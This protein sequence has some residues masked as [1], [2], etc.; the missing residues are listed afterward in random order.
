VYPRAPF[1]LRLAI[2]G[3]LYFVQGLP[4]G[5]QATALPVMLRREDV[6]P[7]AIGLAGALAL[8]WAFK[9]AWAPIVDRFYVRRIGRR[10]TWILPLTLAIGLCAFGASFL[11]P[12]TELAQLCVLLLVMNAL[13]ATMDIAVD[14]LAVDLLAPHELGPGNA[15]QVASFK[16]GM[17]TTGGLLLASVRA[18]GWSGFFTIMSAVIVLVW[19]GALFWREPGGSASDRVTIAGILRAL[20]TSFKRPGF[21]WVIAFIATYK[22]G[23]SAADAM[24][25][26]FLV[27]RGY[28]EAQIGAWVGGWGMIA[29]TAGS[30]A[31]GLVRNRFPIVRAIVLAAALSAI[32]IFGQ[33]WV[34][35]SGI[36]DA[37]M[38]AI[39]LEEHFFGGLLTTLMFAFMMSQVDRTIGA[40]HFTALASVEALGKAPAGLLSGFLVRGVGYSGT[41]AIAGA[42]SLMFLALAIP[43]RYGA[44]DAQKPGPL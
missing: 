34:A 26:P 37:G 1:A 10:R 36:T 42:L 14:G 33:A 31:G 23:E 41:F 32:P 11:D 44:G 4:F 27:D 3:S 16:L 7:E 40:T 13:S 39:T 28:D 12:S 6:S 35:E 22:L 30:L 17:I 38:I 43:L 21:S 2:L 8:P 29:S 25:K 9:L 24:W 15:A 18:I 20:I 5:F 19:I